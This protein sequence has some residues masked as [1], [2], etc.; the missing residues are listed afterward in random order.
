[1]LTLGEIFSFYTKWRLRHALK[2]AS[3]CPSQGAAPVVDFY[4]F[5]DD[6]KRR[7]RTRDEGRGRVG[8]GIDGGR[9]LSTTFAVLRLVYLHR[10][11]FK[12]KRGKYELRPF[13]DKNTHSR[14]T[15]FSF[16]FFFFPPTGSIDSAL[17]LLLL[18]AC[19]VIIHFV[20]LPIM[21]KF[22]LF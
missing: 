18:S 2:I 19:A 14:T 21:R 3:F 5:F 11:K 20:H 8:G 7:R 15:F 13:P 16:L 17:L 6:C 4:S 22:K 9:Q 10:V 12:K 1:M